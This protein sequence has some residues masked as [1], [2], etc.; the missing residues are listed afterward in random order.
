M[1]THASGSRALCQTRRVRALFLAAT[2]LGG[3][4][5]PLL[6]VARGLKER[7]NAVT[8][9]GDADLEPAASEIGLRRLGSDERYDI[10]VAY[11][12]ARAAEGL[13]PAEL[14]ERIADRLIEWSA[15]LAP[16]L[17]EVLT[18]EPFNA[19]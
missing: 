3:D 7:G 6:A 2:K 15:N 19:A 5:P 9:L 4:H 12:E 13:S 8:L 10:S 11:R 17:T 18:T 1:R 14:G 16:A